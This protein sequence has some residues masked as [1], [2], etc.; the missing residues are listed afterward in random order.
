MD[1]PIGRSVFRIILTVTLSPTRSGV[2]AVIFLSSSPFS[3]FTFCKA[4]WSQKYTFRKISLYPNLH[5]TARTILPE[6]YQDLVWLRLLQPVF[7][8][9][10]RFYSRLDIT[11]CLN[12]RFVNSLPPH[13]TVALSASGVVHDLP[14][15]IIV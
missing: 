9:F 6:Q 10:R 13:T 1:I 2:S 5:N 14:L 7:I 8:Q 3:V 12:I 15:F 11:C 4:L